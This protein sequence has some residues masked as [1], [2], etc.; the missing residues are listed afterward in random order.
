MFLKIQDY[1]HEKGTPPD[2]RLVITWFLNILNNEL[3]QAASLAQSKSLIEAQNLIAEAVNKYDMSGDTPNFQ[4]L[5]DLL[6]T[7]VT[8]IT[9]EAANTAA[10]LK[11]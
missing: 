9:S 7:A 11:F 1:I 5:I 3:T 4:T 10:E 8:K 2:G 6:R